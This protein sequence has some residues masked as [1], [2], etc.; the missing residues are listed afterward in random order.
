MTT[1]IKNMAFIIPLTCV[2]LAAQAN[3]NLQTQPLDTSIAIASLQADLQVELEQLK[4]SLVLKAPKA[5]LPA[6]MYAG[7][8]M[9]GQLAKLQRETNERMSIE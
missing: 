3:E 1:L 8:S 6:E 2:G 9:P 7:E 5:V 4:E